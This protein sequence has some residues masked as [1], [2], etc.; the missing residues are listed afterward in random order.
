MSTNKSALN[1][2]IHSN[3]VWYHSRLKYSKRK[4]SG[5]GVHSKCLVPSFNKKKKFHLPKNKTNPSPCLP[6]L[7]WFTGVKWAKQRF[8]FKVKTAG[9]QSL[10]AKQH[11]AIHVCKPRCSNNFPF[12]FNSSKSNKRFLGLLKDCALYKILIS[13]RTRNINKKQS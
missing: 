11:T 4:N 1:K 12:Q 7:L 3:I 5:V 9:F 2:T 6:I 13:L 10:V 8:V